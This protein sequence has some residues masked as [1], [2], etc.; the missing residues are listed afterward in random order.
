MPTTSS[1]RRVSTSSP[2]ISRYALPRLGNKCSCF[3]SEAICPKAGV[4]VLIDRV[5]ML[6]VTRHSARIGVEK[7]KPWVYRG[8]K[9][10][11]GEENLASEQLKRHR[12]RWIYKVSTVLCCEATI[13]RSSISAWK[14]SKQ[15]IV[16]HINDASTV[17]KG[18]ISRLNSP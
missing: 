3:S 10:F 9:S 2:Y 5:G 16:G 1:S 6:S 12:K 4:H 11:V 13:S 17:K 14:S 15:F 18:G 7:G 8:K